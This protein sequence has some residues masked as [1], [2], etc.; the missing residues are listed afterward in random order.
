[1]ATPTVINIHQAETHLSRIV[2]EVAAGGNEVIIAKA[3]RPVAKFVPLAP[4]VQKKHLGLLRGT[5]TIPNA[6]DAPL[7]EGLTAYGGFVTLG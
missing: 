6:F 3:G 5:F 2:E 7:P 1:M 4:V